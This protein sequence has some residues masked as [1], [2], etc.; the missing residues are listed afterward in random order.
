VVLGLR[1]I[2]T[3]KHSEACFLYSCTE[4]TLLRLL[5]FLAR[6]LDAPLDDTCVFRKICEESQA[7]ES[8]GAPGD[9]RDVGC[10]FFFHRLFFD[11][12]CRLFQ[13]GAL[14]EDWSGLS[15]RLQGSSYSGCLSSCSRCFC[16][17]SVGKAARKHL[18]LSSMFMLGVWVKGHCARSRLEMGLSAVSNHAAMLFGIWCEH[19]GFVGGERVDTFTSCVVHTCGKHWTRRA[20]F[21][22]WTSNSEPVPRFYPHRLT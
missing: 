2:T 16:L 4:S 19:G 22:P 5:R 20:S 12:R 21:V 11:V 7:R 9:F 6:K 14:Q 18:F 3:Y 15:T 1:L 13:R 10:R 8:M 17:R